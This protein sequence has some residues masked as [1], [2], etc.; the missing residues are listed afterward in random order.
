[1]TFFKRV[2]SADFRRGLAAEA[3]GDYPVAARAYAL[4]GERAKVSE[5]HLYLAERAATPE[6]RLAELR[7]GV[8]WADEDTPEGRTM[9][10][11]IARAMLA[12]VRM[13]GVV[14]DSDR[15]LLGEAASLFESAG[16]AAGA[17]ECHELAGNE[18]RA[19]DFYQRAGDLE[20]LEAVL[21]REESRRL[22][23][24]RHR[25]AFAEYQLHLRAGARDRAR[26]ALAEALALEPDERYRS[27]LDALD[28]RLL[29]DARVNL[30]IDGQPMTLVGA[31]PLALG[32]EPSCQVPLRDPGISRRHMEV[33]LAGTEFRVRDAGSRNGTFLAGLRLAP[34]GELPLA[35]EV[36]LGL[37]EFCGLRCR[38]ASAG[39]A[40]GAGDSL[41]FLEVVRGLDRGRKVLAGIGALPVGEGAA[42]LRF[43]D[44]RPFFA[45]AA[46][47]GRLVFNGVQAGGSVQLIRG[48]RLELDQGQHVLRI[49]VE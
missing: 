35:G 32:R 8:H 38:V 1:V 29:T 34:G 17:G 13:T 42:A 27:L 20:R 36:E 15:A 4:A 47:G 3:A 31:F 21:G 49:E 30:R 48:D 19:A 9:R 6:A 14:A 5:M 43:V 41:L 37:G 18:T 39:S 11:R 12:Q 25:D 16:D 46:A 28:T 40:A 45:P 7:T 23:E 26:A 44:G 22:A 10:R 24:T 2:F 33:V